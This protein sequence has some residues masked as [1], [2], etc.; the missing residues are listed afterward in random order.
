MQT[1]K[2][3]RGS[4]AEPRTAQP[5]GPLK[6]SGASGEAAGR[7]PETRKAGFVW[8]LPAL[9]FPAI[10]CLWFSF[11]TRQPSM[12]EAGHILNAFIYRDMMAH[13]H[14]FSI[15]WWEKFFSVNQFYPFAVYAFNGAL[16]LV[17]GSG[18]WV[19]IFS[20]ILFDFMLTASTFAIAFILTGR[21]TAAF[22]ASFLINLYPWVTF[23][24]H[25]FLLDFQLI[26]S[27]SLGIA[28]LLWWDGKPDWRRTA[29]TSAALAF[30]VMT[31]QIA[32]CFLIGIGLCFLVDAIRR[33]PENGRNE[34][35]LALVCMVAFSALFF[36]PWIL[37]SSKF[38]STFAQ[39]N[40]ESIQY[41]VG[42]I[43]V[44]QAF[45]RG[46]GFYGASM[47][48][49]MSPLLMAAF[50]A[51]VFLAGRRAHR[52]ILPLTATLVGGILIISCLP[53][54]FPHDR[55]VGSLLIL[56]AVYTGVLLH[57]LFDSK[58]SVLV[59]LAA[60][61]LTLASLQFVSYFFSPFPVSASSS[62][63]GFS[64]A[65]GVTSKTGL[66]DLIG[67]N[68]P[69]PASVDWG[70]K[71]VHETIKTV[72]DGLPVWLNVLAN[73]PDL[74]PQTIELEGKYMKSQV[75]PT[76]SRTWTVMGDRVSFSP[77][78]AL[79]YHWYLLKTGHHGCP[80]IDKKSENAYLSIVNFLKTSG[81]F[82]EVARRAAPDGGEIVLFRQKD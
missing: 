24:G 51:S 55:Y 77:E 76:S 50:I 46:V 65:M 30:A 11:D 47:V 41:T 18:R 48:R 32:A 29:L 39:A 78:T 69:R 37:L 6:V 44:P 8:L 5:G 4:P 53:W 22:F 28:A 49:T 66:T 19:D 57:N 45:L 54:Q 10:T 43:T 61:L 42:Q 82:K 68:I 27:V 26:C 34:R 73:H 38:I 9:L 16:K 72:D 81:K 79:Y 71:W 75:R 7:L 40:Q 64:T 25:T 62:L 58:R 60:L 59:W 70:Q 1:A 36:V 17:L 52:K 35:L 21:R 3:N 13:P 31:K 80:F 15:H 67:K 74:N 20:L 23:L 2:E 12:D 33:T 56:P 14:P 63:T